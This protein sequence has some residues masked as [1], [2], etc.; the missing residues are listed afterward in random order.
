[1]KGV[2]NFS[3][4]KQ[5]NIIGKAQSNTSDSSPVKVTPLNFNLV[6]E[7]QNLQ[8]KKDKKKAQENNNQID[9]GDQD[10]SIAYDEETTAS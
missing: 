6:T 3:D 9:I 2:N 8:R 7:Q 1:M 4:A 10:N 5:R